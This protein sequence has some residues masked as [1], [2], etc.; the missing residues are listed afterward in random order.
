M[1]ANI[2]GVV[3]WLINNLAAPLLSISIQM[4]AG[5]ERTALRGTRATAA[6]CEIVTDPTAPLSALTPLVPSLRPPKRSRNSLS[7]VQIPHPSPLHCK[8]LRFTPRLRC[9]FQG[10]PCV[11]DARDLNVVLIMII[12]MV[13]YPMQASLPAPPA[14]HAAAQAVKVPR[15]RARTQ[16]GCLGGANGVSYFPEQ[17]NNIDCI[18]ASADAA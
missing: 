15:Q 3:P 6:Q 1:N 10:L 9:D 2:T 7:Y 12:P 4:F 14:A 18:R 16:P 11:G 17:A 5:I 13:D 8:V